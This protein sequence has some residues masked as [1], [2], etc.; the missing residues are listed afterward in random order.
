MNIRPGEIQRKS[1][2]RDLK[3][4]FYTLVFLIFLVPAATTLFLQSPHLVRDAVATSEMSIIGAG[5]QNSIM[6]IC[7]V[8]TRIT[9]FVI[10]VLDYSWTITKLYLDDIL[11]SHT[12]WHPF[13]RW[14]GS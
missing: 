12:N 7:G 10:M 1:E 6:V 5:A 4:T 11:A 9:T 13:L 14:V 3:Y 2:Q 8:Y